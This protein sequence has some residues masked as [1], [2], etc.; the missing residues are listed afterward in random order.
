M[1]SFAMLLLYVVAFFFTPLLEHHNHEVEENHQCTAE[2]EVDPCHRFIFHHDIQ[3]GCKHP[4]HLLA[5][6]TSCDACDKLLTVHPKLMDV[7]VHSI[8][9]YASKSVHFIVNESAINYTFFQILTRGP[10]VT[11]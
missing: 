9:Q 10:P 4:E 6:R 3:K 1:L 5:H 11:A 7:P 2:H 8:V